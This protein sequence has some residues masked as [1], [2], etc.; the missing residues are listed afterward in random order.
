MPPRQRGF[1]LIEIMVVVAIIAVIIVGAI[2]SL[3]VTGKD[4]QLERERDRL[5]ALMAYVHERGGMLTLEYGIRCGQ[6]GYRFV[7]FDSVANQWAPET[8]DDTLRPRRIPAGLTF[9]L[10]I[11]GRPIVLDDKALTI[12]KR[13]TTPAGGTISTLGDMT[14]SFNSQL[15]DNSPQI[16][17]F[18]N[19]DMNS[20][21]LTIARDGVGRSAT[22]QSNAD[23]TVKV[24][25]I[26][27]PK[28]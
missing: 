6:H 18:S 25:D 17:L 11:E 9:A 1:T 22:L 2:L 13:D 5:S 12:S 14:S 19:G 8:V 3:G 15:A 10:V 4:R 27:E 23:G 20:F 16:M 21:A 7:Y 26:V 28:P 24:G